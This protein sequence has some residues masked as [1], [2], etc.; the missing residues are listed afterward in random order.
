MSE[1]RINDIE[2]RMYH[3]EVKLQSHDKDLHSIAKSLEGINHQMERTNNLIQDF[4]LKEE[5]FNTRVEKME[6]NITAQI[7]HNEEAIKRSHARTDKIDQI[8]NR[9]AWF[10]ILTM[11][12]GIISAVIK[13]G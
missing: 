6:A 11:L 10:I 3:H 12:T 8:I 13:F 9:L 1:E 5:R 7:K 4:A 2:K